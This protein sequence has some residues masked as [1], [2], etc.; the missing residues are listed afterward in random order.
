MKRC[1]YWRNRIP[2]AIYGD[3]D[4]KT[5]EKLDRHL[6]VCERCSDVYS[7]MAVTVRKMDARPAPDRPPQFWESYWDRLEWR[8]AH[9]IGESEGA[10]AGRKGHPAGGPLSRHR[11]FSVPRWAHGAAAA[12]VFL[13]LGIFIGRN[14][15]RPPA[16]PPLLTRVMPSEPAPGGQ[17]VL[18][19]GPAA[20]P[21]A[22]RASRYLKR[23]RVLLLAVVNSDPRAEDV[24]SLNLPLQKKTSEELVKEAMVLKKEFRSSDRRLERLISD[25]ETILLQIANL[26]SDAGPSAVEIIKAGVESRDILFKIDLN[27]VRRS[28]G[29]SIVG[30]SPGPW[31]E[32][33]NQANV[34]AAAKA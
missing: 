29:K 9:E 32:N 23:S 17:P 13:T 19:T 24:F 20:S 14:L 18:E 6:A 3:L 5:R 28:A 21:L 1:H 22:I 10:R 7:G 27:V 4:I 2:E 34:K 16:E 8:M 26:K 25:L 12:M 15:L 30:Q 33:R 31:G 11:A